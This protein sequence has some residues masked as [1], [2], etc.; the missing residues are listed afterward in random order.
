MM[1]EMMEL[2]EKGYGYVEGSMWGDCP[3]VYGEEAKEEILE[4]AEIT[5]E[6][7]IDHDQEIIY[8]YYVSEDY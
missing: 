8:G 7:S 1:K 6:F 3:A 5:V 2:I 4:D